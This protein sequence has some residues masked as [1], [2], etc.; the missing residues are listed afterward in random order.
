MKTKALITS[1]ALIV[2]LSGCASDQNQPIVTNDQVPQYCSSIGEPVTT[3]VIQSHRSYCMQ[4][5]IAD[6]IYTAQTPLAYAFSIVDDL[7]KVVKDFAITHTKPMHIIVVRKD[8]TGFQHLHPDFNQNT[9]IFTLSEITFP[10]E[11]QYRIFADFAASGGQI[12]AMA[13]PMTTTIF[14]DVQVGKT[15]E[16]QPIGTQERSKTIA[17]YQVRLDTEPL[18]V[19]GKET[20]LTFDLK[21]NG[22]AV[23][24]LQS[25]LGALGHTVILR[26]GS[27]DFI[28]A[29]PLEAVSQPQT[30]KVNFMVDFPEAGTYKVF[31][32]FQKDGK[33]LTTDFV[34]TVGEGKENRSTMDMN[35]MSGKD[36]SMMGH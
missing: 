24:D 7:G 36:H 20:T 32:Q 13:M 3:P 16:P 31:T 6:T 8:L 4:S 17:G 19:S 26:E 25:Y 30:G 14:Q 23:T 29:H 18:I 1:M 12:D 2:V 11:G 28:H 5:S 15:Y 10:T 22:K 21:Q 34:I 9:G 27:L 33:V 35:N